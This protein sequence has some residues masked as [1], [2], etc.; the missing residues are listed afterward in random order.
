MPEFPGLERFEGDWYHTARWPDEGVDLTGQR[1]GVIG[2]GSS[3][4]QSSR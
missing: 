4:V 1:V 3:G 2:T